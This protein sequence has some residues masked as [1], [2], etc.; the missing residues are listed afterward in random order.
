MTSSCRIVKLK[1]RTIEYH[2]KFCNLLIEEIYAVSSPAGSS[3]KRKYHHVKC[4][5]RVG[6]I[7]EFDYY[8]WKVTIAANK[9][10]T[11]LDPTASL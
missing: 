6:L 7:T 4:A 1:D 9:A 8:Q 5:L 10:F 2:C 11:F 3:G